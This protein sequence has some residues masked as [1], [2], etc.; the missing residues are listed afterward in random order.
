MERLEQAVTEAQGMGQGR[1]MAKVPMEPRRTLHLTN[2]TDLT[3][4][5]AQFDRLYLAITNQTVQ[6]DQP[7]KAGTTVFT[8]D[9]IESTEPVTKAKL[10][11]QS[12][13]DIFTARNL[14]CWCKECRGLVT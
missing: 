14:R 12:L 6:P 11:Q 7:I 4:P 2:G 13:H 5:E 10:A 9:D 1:V 8:W 3:I